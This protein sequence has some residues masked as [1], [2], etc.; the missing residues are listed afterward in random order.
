MTDPTTAAFGAWTSPITARSLVA[1]AAGVSEVVVDG[2]DIWWNESRP[3]E[4]GR[5]ALVRWRDRE[6]SEP[7]GSD[8]NVRTGVHEYGGGAWW[9]ADNTLWFTDN[10]DQRLRRRDFDDGA[11]FSD[12]VLLTPEPRVARGLRWADGRPS[13][14]KAWYVCVRETH[15]EPTPQNAHPEPANELVAVAGDGS[16]AVNLLITG[17]DFVSTPRLSP[18]NTR[19][20]WIQ[21]DHPNMPWDATELWVADFADGRIKNA[22]QIAGE[23]GKESIL[24]PEWS[25]AGNLHAVT[26]RHEWW[27]LWRWNHADNFAEPE[28]MITGDFEIA[29][30][31][32]VFN[33]TRHAMT[34]RGVVA[35]LGTGSGDRLRLADGTELASWSSLSSLRAMGEHVV[36]VGGRWDADPGVFRVSRDASVETIRAGRSAADLGVDPALLPT[37]R[38]ITFPVGDPRDEEVAHALFYPPSNPEFEGPATERPPLLVKVH[39]G[40]TGMA[41]TQMQLSIAYWTSRGVAVVDVNFR[42]STGYGRTYRHS[43]RGRWGTADVED[44]VAA[45][46]SLARRGDVDGDR[47]AIAGGSAGGFT[48]LAAL[49]FHDAFAV[50]ASRYGIADLGVLATDTHKFEARY[51]DRLVGPWPEAKDVYDDRSPINFTDGLSCPMIILQGGEDKVVPPNQAEM[52]V[53]AIKRK[54]LAHAYVYFESEGHGFREADNIVTALESELSFFGQILGF[55]PADALPPLEIKNL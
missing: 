6:I 50:G 23:S 34:A 38:H 52:M 51:C 29:T 24:E 46:A 27:N 25:P 44:C 15:D 2:H 28:P 53:E 54:G 17:P 41:R 10:Q 14:D 33:M 4:R 39:G 20:S 45:A 43:L 40:P 5:V 8:I 31:H 21:W 16:G 36:F 19:L 32:W 7:A 48:V 49:T 18:D 26:D 47:L 37:P 30:P 1:G 3:E 22:R 13:T 55:T 35:A 42:G 11:G 12:A 9:V